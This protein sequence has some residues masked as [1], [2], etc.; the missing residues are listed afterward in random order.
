MKNYCADLDLKMPLFKS[1]M[2]PIELLKIEYHK[3]YDKHVTNLYTISVDLLNDDIIK[4]LTYHGLDIKFIEVFY[5]PPGINS[6]IHLDTDQPG[7]YAKLNWVFGGEGSLM[8]WYMVNGNYAGTKKLTSIST[9]YIQYTRDE[10][11]LLHSQKVAQ[12]SLVQVGIP[13]GISNNNLTE[14]FCVSLIFGYKDK[15]GRP[16]FDKTCKILK[17]YI[18]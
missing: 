9:Y 14:R 5:R 16:T 7:D 4:L 11:T 13:H 6:Y 8:D 10:V 1:S 2:N 15:M 12:P 18:I 3:L 17:D